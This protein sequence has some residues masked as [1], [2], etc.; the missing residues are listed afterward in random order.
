MKEADHI[1]M[2]SFV[3][4][5]LM[6]IALDRVCVEICKRKLITKNEFQLYCHPG[7]QFGKN[8]FKY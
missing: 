5:A 7:W 1:D 8:T 3:S 4:S 2:A 6:M